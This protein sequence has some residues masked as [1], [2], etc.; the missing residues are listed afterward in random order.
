MLQ[1]ERKRQIDFKSMTLVMVNF[2]DES[3]HV[4]DKG[5]LLIIEEA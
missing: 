2:F 1:N 4:V 3:L 5:A